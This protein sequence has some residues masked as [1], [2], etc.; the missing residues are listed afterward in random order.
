M[1]ILFA[2]SND[3]VSASIMK[4]YQQKY[5]EIITSKNV[6]YFN[7]IIKELQ[8]DK[9]YDVV[10][11]GEDLEPISTNNYETIDKFIFEKL[12]NI[13]DEA[14]KA[15]GEDIPIILIC[16]DRR[17]KADQLLIKLFG[18]GIYNALLGNDRNI[19]A[20]C[21]LINKPRSKKEAKSYYRIESDDV[22][23]KPES[24]SE[25]SEVEVQNILSHY[26]KIGSNEKKCVESFDSIAMQYTDTQLR[27]IVNYLP[28]NVK[29]ILEANSAR[30]QKLMTGGTVLSNGAYAPYTPKNNAPKNK[31]MD[32]LTKDL[33]KPK[34][35]KPVIIPSTMEMSNVR[36]KNN[37]VQGMNNIAKM[38]EEQNV[39]NDWQNLYG[40]S[41]KV[42][43][44]YNANYNM[45]TQMQNI[46]Q[47]QNNNFVTPQNGL[48]NAKLNEK[49]KENTQIRESYAQINEGNN[50]DKQEDK[51]ENSKSSE[52]IE[53]KVPKKRG[54]PKK[55]T[56]E[57]EIE[58][59]K[60]VAKRGRGRPKKVVEEQNNDLNLFGLSNEIEE[61]K[62]VKEDIEV[63]SAVLPGFEKTEEA[64]EQNNAQD[65][66]NLFAIDSQDEK[67]EEATNLF[68]LDNFSGPNEQV[69]DNNQ[70]AYGM[71]NNMA[72]N[73]YGEVNNM[74]QNPYD[75]VNNM[76]QN[77]YGEMNNM[78]QNPYDGVNNI[79]QN[80]YGEINN[81]V[82]NPYDG[83]NNMVQN[84]YD[85]VNNM[86]QN[87]YS[88]VNTTAQSPYA[89]EELVETLE[90]AIEPS[91]FMAKNSKIIS[92]VGT[93]KN[94]TSFIVN[95]L[96]VLLSQRGIKTAILDLTKN[97]N[98]YYMFTDNDQVLMGKAT[99]SIKKLAM[100]QVEGVPVNQNLTVFTSLPGDDMELSNVD[101]ILN[102]LDSSYSAILMDCD[103]NT[104]IN[105][106]IKS[107]E[108]YL[109]QTMDAL[110]IQ[111]LTLF[112]SELKLKGAL[113]ES[114]LRVIVNKEIKLKLL[115][116]KMILGG[117]AKYN[118]PSMTLQ[119]DLF[120]PNNIKYVKVPFEEQ[121]Y[122][123][124]IEAIALCQI[125]LSGYSEKF[126]AS[127]NELANMV[128]PLVPG[129][130]NR[131]HTDYS[132]NY[133]KA[134]KGG[135]FGN[136][137]KKQ[138]NTQFSS[139]VN[140]TLDKMRSN[141]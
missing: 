34:L 8:K 134:K 139:G 64:K 98:S 131:N 70:N 136:K 54:R 25:V 36:E 1:K 5:K 69:D 121:T 73:P 60:P 84:P 122:A 39:Q 88:E 115:N 55:V 116:E 29:A 82:Q 124:Y 137:N 23:Y 6:Y 2:V 24:E 33:E 42:E 140:G 38:P 85:G 102:T 62:D 108:M 50:I 19:D 80:P 58:E 21:E 31:D 111:P 93:S 32:F 75:G 17:T 99:N 20:V 44:P 94:G 103:F 76:A 132:P 133:E 138:A 141:Y 110:T 90:P 68:G 104:N 35:T 43:N 66:I 13:S 67:K 15:S 26:K 97:K 30:Y 37:A 114:K 128:F 113:D 9:S 112:L 125:S 77:P 22:N 126:M 127:L 87:P 123:R 100:G 63:T 11:I 117:M 79:A 16:S 96:A 12:D 89:R 101:M 59:A 51:K 120:N 129:G 14:Y 92:F 95:N 10:I 41:N 72:Q 61:K 45:T 74:A 53:V 81:M 91:N 4:K 105:Y 46:N 106:F 27:I 57:G 130:Q 83:V 52:E 18:I 71:E 28:M 3:N 47:M 109:V 135:W 86:A 48:E 49:N 56:T 119:R 7:A 107:T 40:M 78:V 118:E 65:N